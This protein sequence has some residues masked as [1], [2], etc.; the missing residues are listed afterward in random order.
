MPAYNYEGVKMS[1]NDQTTATAFEKAVSAVHE[2]LADN[3]GRVSKAELIRNLD[4]KPE[5]HA[6]VRSHFGLENC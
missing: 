5:T 1:N 4:L 6:Q 2:A 3:Q